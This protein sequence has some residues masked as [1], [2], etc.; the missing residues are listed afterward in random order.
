MLQFNFTVL[1][2]LQKPKRI[3][4]PLRLNWI[5]LHHQPLPPSNY[6]DK[7]PRPAGKEHSERK[8]MLPDV[9]V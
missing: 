8:G 3:Q 2:Y 1:S 7:H 5:I 4:F 6:H 9:T